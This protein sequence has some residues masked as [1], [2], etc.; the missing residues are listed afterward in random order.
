MKS[1]GLKLTWTALFLFI[2]AYAWRNDLSWFK[3]RILPLLV[4]LMLVSPRFQQ[5][6]GEFMSRLVLTAIYV[7]ALPLGVGVKLF[8][9]PLRV[10]TRNV[11]TH[12][13]AR[14]AEDE[15]L[16]GAGKQG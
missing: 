16:A 3:W 9:D 8:M 1:P 7:C 11:G 10:K 2:E 15:S 4:W 12:W 14:P 13:I 6:W 5:R